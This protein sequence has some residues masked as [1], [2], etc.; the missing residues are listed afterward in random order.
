MDI[1]LKG[2]IHRFCPKIEHFLI[3]FFTKIISGNIV[4]DIVER[5]E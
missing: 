2:L 3:A 5:K 1:F 4:F